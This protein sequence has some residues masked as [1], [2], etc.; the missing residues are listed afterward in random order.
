[1]SRV[2]HLVL[3]IE[4]KMLTPTFKA[5]YMRG[6]TSADL[7]RGSGVFI[8]HMGVL[9]LLPSLPLRPNAFV[10]DLGLLPAGQVVR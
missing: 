5:V 2:D 4:T 1:M 10:N 6:R 8:G 7:A 9:F 3:W